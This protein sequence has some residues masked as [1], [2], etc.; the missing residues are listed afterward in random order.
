MK[1]EEESK[2]MRR[3]KLSAGEKEILEA[4]KRDDFVPV[5]GKE[6]RA[7][8]DAVAVRKKDM[9]STIQDHR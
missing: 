9:T 5:G 7:V 3:I 2:H 8:A 1:L 4:I 6:L